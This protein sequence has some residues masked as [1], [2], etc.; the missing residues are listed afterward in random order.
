MP[1]ITV[2]HVPSRVVQ[3]LKALAKRHNRSMEQEV[4]E[5][6]EGYAVERRAVLD[7]I[8]TAWK[9]QSR[10]PTAAEID[11]WMAVGRP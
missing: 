1:T 7:Q 6:L 3:T 2:R 8:E 4:R 9:K 11:A 5:I 10:R